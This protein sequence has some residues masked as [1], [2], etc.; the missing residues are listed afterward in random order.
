[1]IGTVGILMCAVAGRVLDRAEG[2]R[3]LRRMIANGYWS[4]VDD[5]PEPAPA[6][7]R[8]LPDGLQ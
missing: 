1:L 7:L 6:S 3:L 5:L 2:E 4:P 8:V